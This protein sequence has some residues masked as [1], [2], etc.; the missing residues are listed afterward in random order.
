MLTTQSVP[1]SIVFNFGGFTDGDR[2][3]CLA[4][5]MGTKNIILEGFN[6]ENPTPKIGTSIEIKAKKLKWA[7]K[8]IFDMNPNDIN[9]LWN[10]QHI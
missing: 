5:H 6:F 4:R 9:I 8:I 1:S 3:V 10:Q 7:K 2:A